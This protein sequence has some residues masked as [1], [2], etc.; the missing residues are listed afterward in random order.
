M[1]DSIFASSEHDKKNTKQKDAVK[2]ILNR[3]VQKP[4]N[5]QEGQGIFG[6]FLH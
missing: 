1:E 2:R 6:E 3:S 5:F 4:D